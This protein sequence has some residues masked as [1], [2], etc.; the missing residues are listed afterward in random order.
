[1]GE[2]PTTFIGW[3]SFLIE[4]FGPQFVKGT[5]TTLQLAFMGTVLGC[6]LGFLVGIVQSI[7]VDKHSSPLSRGLV[8]VLKRIVAVY[9]EVFRGTPMMVQAMVIYYGSAQAWGIDLDPFFSGI[10]VLSLTTG[11]Y[12]AESV[13]GAI[14]GIDPGQLEGAYAIGFTHVQAMTRVIIPQAFRNLIPQIGNMFISSISVVALGPRFANATRGAQESIGYD[15]Q[16][17][18]YQAPKPIEHFVDTMSAGDT[19]LTGFVV[20]WFSLTKQ[21]VDGADRIER[22]LDYAATAAARACGTEGSWGH[23]APVQ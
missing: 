6:L 16:R 11:A 21:G 19:F 13:R 1:M 5:I 3:V 2:V 20:M 4:R 12:M 10:L 15:D 9:V 7:T 18:Y 14:T 23:G 17:F 22:A 8:K